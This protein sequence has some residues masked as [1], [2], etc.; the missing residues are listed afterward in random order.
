MVLQRNKNI[1][2]WGTVCD[3]DNDV[4]T[5]A[6]EHPWMDVD[7]FYDVKCDKCNKLH[8]I[9]KD[10]AATFYENK[11]Y[12]LFKEVKGSVLELGSGGGF[13]TKYLS[14]KSDVDNILAID[15]DDESNEYATEYIHGDLNKFK[16]FNITKRF[17]YVVCRDVFMYLDDLDELFHEISKISSK[18][19]FLNWY[20]P[21]HKNCHNKTNPVE[22]FELLKKYYKDI[23][24]VY[25]PFYKWGYLIRSR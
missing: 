14:T 10:M 12:G 16:D 18:L 7:V 13:I 23:E 22:I 21:Y 1:N 4:Y 3:C 19:L 8:K 5:F 2:I 11:I 15:I 20:N 17:D 6:N 25:P 9:N 24:I